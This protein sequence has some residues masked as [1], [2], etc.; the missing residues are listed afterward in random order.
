MA[1]AFLGNVL[2]ILFYIAFSSFYVEPFRTPRLISVY[3]VISVF[4][5]S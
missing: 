3:S 1:F 4:F 2:L 5:K